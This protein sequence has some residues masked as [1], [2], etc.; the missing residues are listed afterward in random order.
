MNTWKVRRMCLFS[1]SR[2]SELPYSSVLIS[3]GQ[4]GRVS[5]VFVRIVRTED[6]VSICM[7]TSTPCPLTIP[8]C[9]NF[10]LLHCRQYLYRHLRHHYH[11]RHLARCTFLLP[12]SRSS[13]HHCRR[14]HFFVTIIIILLPRHHYRH[15]YHHQYR[16]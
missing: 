6:I 3:V 11:Q 16:P 12:L 2:R 15:S 9:F 8:S 7:E 13:H 4:L 5:I 10:I 1:G 14:R